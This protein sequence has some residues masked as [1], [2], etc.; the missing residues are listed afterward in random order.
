MVVYVNLCTVAM[1]N[2][3]ESVRRARGPVQ[4]FPVIKMLMSAILTLVSN[5]HVLY[6]YGFSSVSVPEW[7]RD[8]GNHLVG[9]VTE[10]FVG[11][12]QEGCPPLKVGAQVRN[13]FLAISNFDFGSTMMP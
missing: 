9:V 13:F 4:L 12:P 6:R 7:A 3:R 11:F 2:N 8:G 10:N 5:R 1:R